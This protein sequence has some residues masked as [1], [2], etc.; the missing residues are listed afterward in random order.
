MTSETDKQ[1]K[2]LKQTEA[3]DLIL[4]IITQLALE[5]HHGKHSMHQVSL[6]SM[7]DRDLELDSLSRVEL[8]QRIERKFQIRL[9]EKLLVTA[10]T[11][12]DLL[13]GVI[14]APDIS[15]DSN[16]RSHISSIE[17]TY[18]GTLETSPDHAQT[19]I[20]V[21]QWHVKKHPQRP[22]IYLYGDEDEPLTISY[23]VLFE[24]AKKIASGL[25][26]YGIESGQTV[27]IMLP[28]GKDYLFTFFAI[29]LAGAIPVPIYP[30]TRPSQLE[31]HLR[32]HAKILN[33]AGSV[34]LIT[35]KEAKLPGQLLKAQVNN[36]R[37][38]LVVK[39]LVDQPEQLVPVPVQGDDIAFL[40]YTSGSTG[41]PKGVM[42]THHNLLAN[43]RAMGQVVQAS[44]NDV[45]VS[46]LP[47]YHDMGLIGA[48]LGSLYYASPLVL[49]SPLP[50]LTRPSRWFWAIHKHRGTLS[51]APNFA[52]E[53]CLSKIKDEDIEGLDLS[54]WRM[55][56]NGAEPVNP[57]TLREFSTRFEH[58]GFHPEALS[59]VYGLAES[60]VG[61]AFPPPGRGALIDCVQRDALQLSGAAVPTEAGKN[62]SML[63]FAACGQPLPGYQIRV[64]DDA[65]RELPERREGRLQFQGP[66]ATSGYYHNPEQTRLLFDNDWL[67]TGDLAYMVSGEIYLTGRVKEM[68][69]RAGRN[70]YPYEVEQAVGEIT[71]V[72]K[73]CVAV[74]GVHDQGTSTERIIVLAETRESEPEILAQ[75]HHDV[76]QV[77][78]GMLLGSSPDEILI[79]PPHS[80]LK[81]SSG[82][83]RRTACRDLYVQGQLNRSHRSIG[84]QLI[85]VAAVSLLPQLKKSFRS[86]QRK[87]QENLFALWAW[88]T[89]FILAPITWLS[90]ILLPVYSW[91]R[92][93]IRKIIQLFS[94]V[95]G[96]PLR[97][98]G[99]QNL[100]FGKTALFVCNH[101]SYLD[102]IMLMAALPDSFSFVAK[103]EL[104]DNFI[105]RLFL[106]RIGCIFV[107]R[108]DIQGGAADAKVLHEQVQKGQSLVI[109]PEG[110][111]TRI[112]GLRPFRMGAF[113]TAAQTGKPVIPLTLSGTRSILGAATWF[114]RQGSVSIHISQPIYPLDSG[115]NE[116]IRLRDKA[117]QAILQHY[118]EP[119]L[120]Q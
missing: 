40:Q 71:R 12:R 103:K 76:D 3:A 22:H 50:F 67:E 36:L 96:I 38:V 104:E 43:I 28:T 19:L 92:G 41:T 1:N 101:A 25:Q 7:L 91:R 78:S 5:M 90:V 4:Q 99:R 17:T 49:M 58:Y 23:A 86:F 21:L 56:F 48:W 81:T 14:N 112:T 8:L 52:Y 27:A 45:F 63:E 93:F 62:H 64:V 114:P 29:L 110:T 53:F 89:F 118:N 80:V 26:N 69:I 37:H 11:P 73:G 120:T 33:N 18:N 97:V 55:A 60:A 34:L 20:D 113:T 6:D 57:I 31:E 94:L 9:P 106:Q 75:L 24:S 83:I 107:E 117:R 105:P 119:D 59:P 13:Q 15:L 39:E 82:K 88:M 46:W 116:A 10:E 66:S 95:T 70:I 100:I 98:Y 44:S 84:L 51:A 115:W 77:T 79:L 87:I 47:L 65:G 61:L 2:R 54:S 42:L 109:F 72:R 30:P 16:E 68:I 108:F 35:I 111:F 85:R 74:F 102:G 32:R